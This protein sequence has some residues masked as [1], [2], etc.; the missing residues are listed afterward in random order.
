[1]T[2]RHVVIAAASVV[3]LAIPLLGS[4]PTVPS[5]RGLLPPVLFLVLLAIGVVRYGFV[6]LRAPQRLLPMLAEFDGAAPKPP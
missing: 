4:L 3:L 6:R 5:W 1:L 2:S